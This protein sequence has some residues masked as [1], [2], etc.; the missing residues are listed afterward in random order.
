[1]GSSTA[2]RDY[3]TIWIPFEFGEVNAE[4]WDEKLQDHEGA[5]TRGRGSFEIVQDRLIAHTRGPADSE[6]VAAAIV[7]LGR[8]SRGSSSSRSAAEI[9]ATI[10]ERMIR[11][12]SVDITDLLPYTVQTTLFE[13]NMNKNAVSADRADK[14]AVL[15]K[16][17]YTERDVSDALWQSGYD[18][19]DHSFGS[20]GLSCHQ[21]LLTI[22]AN[23]PDAG[24][25][26]V[27]RTGEETILPMLTGASRAGK[28][29][30][31]RDVKVG[32]LAVFQVTRKKMFGNEVELSK[33][34]L[35]H[36]AIIIR[37]G[38]GS[39]A[40]VELLEKKDPQEFMSTR[41]VAEV[42]YDYRTM[43]VTVRFVRPDANFAAI[44]RD[45]LGR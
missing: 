22:L 9:R 4:M 42:L 3:P 8:F 19:N 7:V 32:D 13:L 5:A 2:D 28:P 23:E 15:E 11:G 37:V 10:T 21:F 27:A 43:A 24:E 33:D 6:S 41:T 29:I 39:L 35:I 38:G 16:R 34:E 1:M 18:E 20:Y 17:E 14:A 25:G 30:P 26:T 45:E 12:A 31:L 40:D 44:R 36:S